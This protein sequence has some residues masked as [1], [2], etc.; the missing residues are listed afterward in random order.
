MVG[1][2]RI[3]R[4][5]LWALNWHPLSWQLCGPRCRKLRQIEGTTMLDVVDSVLALPD[6]SNGSRQT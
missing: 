5:L 1:D 3:D 2:V 6:L 4:R